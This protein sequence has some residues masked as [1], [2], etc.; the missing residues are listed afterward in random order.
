MKASKYASGGLEEFLSQ[1]QSG[2][3]G[4]HALTD[5]QKEILK[6]LVEQYPESILCGVGMILFNNENNLR[7]YRLPIK[8]SG[9]FSNEDLRVDRREISELNGSCLEI[10]DGVVKVFVS[11]YHALGLPVPE[12][13][14]RVQEIK[15]R[16][17]DYNRS[18]MILGDRDFR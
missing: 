12:C 9:V 15:A 4:C 16:K 1:I 11:A 3:Y 2:Q 5:F 18:S 10:K 7:C 8:L 13:E 17:L 6:A 14:K